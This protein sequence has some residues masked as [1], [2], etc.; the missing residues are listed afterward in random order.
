MRRKPSEPTEEMMQSR[1]T[2]LLPELAAVEHHFEFSEHVSRWFLS[3][4][5][6]GQRTIKNIRARFCLVG[7][8]ANWFEMDENLQTSHVCLEQS[9]PWICSEWAAELERRHNSIQQVRI[10]QNFAVETIKTVQQK[11]WNRVLWF[12]T[13]KMIRC[14]QTPCSAAPLHQT[15]MFLFLEPVQRGAAQ[16]DPPPPV[17]VSH[18]GRTGRFHQN[19]NQ[20]FILT[21]PV[22]R[23]YF[24][25]RWT[26]CFRA[27]HVD[28]LLFLPRVVLEKW[29]DA[30]QQWTGQTEPEP[31]LKAASLK[32][33][34]R[35]KRFWSFCLDGSDSG[36]IWAL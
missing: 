10:Q 19:W 29:V 2:A 14:Y 4:A 9:L 34:Y 11:Q 31:D 28:L 1:R 23:F 17:L 7:S 35:S 6:E 30:R 36:P 16:S 5:T 3:S 25:H 24:L 22:R 13:R 33:C 15:E 21:R 8:A 27:K 32:F 12:K 20:S 26:S 18:M